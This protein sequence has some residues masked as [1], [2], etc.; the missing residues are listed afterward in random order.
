MGHR[1]AELGTSALTWR[2]LLVIAKECPHGSP[3]YR[4][5]NGEESA[6]WGL[7]QQLLA[8]IFDTLRLLVW[9]QSE[10]GAEGRNRPKPLPRPGVEPDEDKSV[11]GRAVALVD[12]AE[13]LA[14]RNPQQHKPA[15]LAAPDIEEAR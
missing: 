5:V 14:R 15:A 1:L 10:D 8:S 6:A 12:M 7:D 9:M 11:M 3:L 13:W 4:A 2:D